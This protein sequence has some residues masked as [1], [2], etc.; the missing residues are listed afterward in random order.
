M[1]SHETKG[2]GSKRAVRTKLHLDSRL[3]SRGPVSFP[4]L[5]EHD[6]TSRC[7]LHEGGQWRALSHAFIRP[8]E[9]TATRRTGIVFTAKTIATEFD[10]CSADVSLIAPVKLR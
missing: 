1:L 7:N 6:L 10:Q 4:A 8:L 5:L 2:G 3:A 9:I